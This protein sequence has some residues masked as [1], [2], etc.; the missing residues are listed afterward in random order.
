MS[1]MSVLFVLNTVVGYV[2]I[3]SQITEATFQSLFY[4]IFI[5]NQNSFINKGTKQIYNR[6]L[7]PART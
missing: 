5:D 4:F 2:A 7:R 6:T 1:S 3:V